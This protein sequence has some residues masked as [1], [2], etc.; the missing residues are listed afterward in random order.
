MYGYKFVSQFGDEPSDT[1]VSCMDG[2]TSKQMA[3]GLKKSLDKH[4]EWPPAAVEFRAMCLGEDEEKSWEHGSLAYKKFDE[5]TALEILPADEE[6]Q[7]NAFSKLK[8]MF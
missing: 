1:W 4:K 3:D 6:T 2:I 5:S 7:R 8:A